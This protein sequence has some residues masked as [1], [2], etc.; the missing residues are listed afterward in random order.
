MTYRDLAKGVPD[1]GDSTFTWGAAQR[2]VNRVPLPSLTFAEMG[3]GPANLFLCEELP[4]SLA[5]S[6]C[7]VSIS[8]C[9][10]SAICLARFIASSLFPSSVSVSAMWMAPWWCR[11]IPSR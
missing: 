5:S 6:S 3:D 1:V 4:Q 10:V 11:I 7:M 9:W 2:A 8:C